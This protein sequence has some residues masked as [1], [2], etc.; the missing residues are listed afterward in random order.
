MYRIMFDGEY[1]Y[2]E[3]KN[4]GEAVEIWRV[5]T[6]AEWKREKCFEDGDESI[7][8]ESVERLSTEPVLR[9]ECS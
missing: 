7:E 3:A 2:V 5:Y 6:I 4:Y 8:P 1:R 9:G